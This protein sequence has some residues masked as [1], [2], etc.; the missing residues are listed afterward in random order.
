MEYKS[1]EDFLQAADKWIAAYQEQLRGEKTGAGGVRTGGGGLL[2]LAN[3]PLHCMPYLLG[4]LYYSIRLLRDIQQTRKKLQGTALGTLTELKPTKKDSD[5]PEDLNKAATD[6]LVELARSG[7]LKPKG[8]VKV[9]W[10]L[11]QKYFPKWPRR[12]KTCSFMFSNTRSGRKYFL[13]P[14]R[15]TLVWRAKR[16]ESQCLGRFA[17]PTLSPNLEG[18]RPRRLALRSNATDLCQASPLQAMPVLTSPPTR[19]PVTLSAKW[20][21]DQVGLALPP[22]RH[23]G[24]WPPRRGLQR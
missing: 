21:L 14:E 6:L 2:L 17:L 3:G 13:L 12:S 10:P 8:L 11:W 18:F 20:L 16:R 23:G 5:P 9:V 7:T 4:I 22:P 1:A 24:P 19:G 15:L